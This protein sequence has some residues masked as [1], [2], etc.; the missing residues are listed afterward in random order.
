MV[1]NMAGINQDDIYLYNIG[2]AQK[3]WLTMGAHYIPERGAY[4]FCVWAPNAA[5]VSVVGD[6]NGWD[7]KQ[8]PM[9]KGE[10]GI[11]VGYS[12][13][14][15]PG[16]CYKYYIVG[17]DGTARYKADPFAFY[18]ELRPNTA[19]RICELDGYEWQ[20]AEFIKK[21]DK[22][23]QFRKP[24]SI[25]ELHLGSW[26]VK[27]DGSFYNYREIADQLAPYIK[28]MGF[29][30]VELMPITEHPF[31]GSWGYQVTGYF[32]VTARYGTPQD[33]MY[34]VDRMH[35]EGIGVLL[36]W[37]PAHFP[38]DAH[39]LARFDGTCLYEHQNPLQGEQPQWGTL[40]FNYGR[41]EVQSF[42]VSS[43]MFFV[44]V[45]HIDG[46]RIDAVSSMLYLD[47]GRED[48]Q[49]IPNK[50]GGNLNLEA[51]E[52]LKKLNASVLSAY[53]GVMTIAEESS[54]Y[55]MVTRPPYDGGLGFSFKWDMGFMHDTLDYMEL[56]HLYRRDHH[57]K[58]TFSMHYAFSENY[59]LAF[60][61]DEVVHGKRSM[62]GK[63][64]GDYWQQFASLRA[65]YGYMYA[66][67]GKKLLFMGSEF[68]QFIEWDYQKELDW[69]L[70]EYDSHRKMREYVKKLNRLYR[71]YRAFYEIDDG[72]DGFRWMNV[73]DHDNSA[74]AFLRLARPYRGK[75]QQLLCVLNF[76]PVVREHYKVA[77]PK[78]G[79]LKCVLNSDDTAFGGSG[80]TPSGRKE[81]RVDGA[82]FLGQEASAELT[83][84]PLSAMYFEYLPDEE[85]SPAK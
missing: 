51:I 24:V 56:D 3:A 35:Q 52:L 76:T 9:E 84:P 28:E 44:E 17:Y 80:V 57:D 21:R 77:L 6:F 55:P 14:A 53:P 5:Q 27:P 26:R 41:P 82:G 32:S 37:V 22:Q 42:L 39:G 23:P 69:F 60:S 38:R 59:I 64:F 78:K 70:D 63:M 40:I 81:L 7:A 30:H 68:A 15:E 29:T 47:F 25:Y 73:D 13:K 18:S 79:V 12:D 34:F 61:H 31:D 19:S 50:D 74:A 49:F 72:W 1:S 16:N 45:Y 54:S 67:P 33:F 65:M 46:L 43:A 71:K 20:D 4:R 85:E 8:L 36:D 48:G 62:I 66:H 75:Q 10:G 2:N 83:L 11:F 58:L